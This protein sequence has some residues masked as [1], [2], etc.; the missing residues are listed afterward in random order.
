WTCSCPDFALRQLPCK[1]AFALHAFLTRLPL[2]TP[3]PAPPRPTY[4]QDWPAYTR[5]QLSEFRLFHA[6]LSDLTAS[7][8]DPRPPQSR[9]R[10][11]LPFP[12]LLF[13]ALQK[14]YLQKSLRR[15]Y[16]QFELAAYLHHIQHV[17]SFVMP[18]VLFQREDL[19]PILTD[20][21]ARS[22]QPLSRLESTFAV[23]ASGYRTTSFG[24]YCQE[25]HG[26]SRAN[27]WMKAHVI[28]GVATHTIPAV[29]VTSGT[30]ADCLQ[31]STLVQTVA[32]AGFTLR[33]IC[34]DK[35]YLSRENLE[36]AKTLGAHP[37]IPFKVGSTS[38][39]QGST[40]WKEM[41][42]FFHEHRGEFEEHYHARSNVE[43][44]FASVKRKLGET[45]VSKDVVARGNELLA[46]MLV[47]NLT[48]L[49]HEMYEHRLI[50]EFLRRPTVPNELRAA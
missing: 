43:A 47:Y 21:V 39:A 11:R 31:F 27:V 30:S 33:E 37:Y 44:V 38:Q 50:P 16:G 45:L 41:F 6:L 25:T 15:V 24:A 7:L 4:P 3:S 18:S 8:V 14:V 26:P 20:L 1:R 46:K 49:V 29:V 2:P 23:D 10:P 35:A 13:C 48:V 12:D 22:A 9:G 42:H 40:M 32:R 17:P 19:T 36:M 28:V 34:A 5:A